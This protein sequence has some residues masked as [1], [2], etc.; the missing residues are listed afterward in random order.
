[1]ETERDALKASGAQADKKL[2]ALRAS[3]A[4][5]TESSEIASVHLQQARE[6]L[7][8]MRSR[9]TAAHDDARL[10]KEEVDR[11]KPLLEEVE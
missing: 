1:M 7:S 10:A 11:L 3:E 5:L 2:S 8:V 9:V 6:D 4:S